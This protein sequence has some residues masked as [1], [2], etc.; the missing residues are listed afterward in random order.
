MLEV[1]SVNVEVT[2]NSP[3][4]FNNTAIKKGCTADVSSSATIQ[5]NKRGV[6]MVS[7]DGTSSAATTLQLIKDGIAHPQA[8]ST[9]TEPSFVTLVQVDHDN[10]NC[11]CSSPV[12]LQVVS[13]TAVTL[14]NINLVVTKIC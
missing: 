10:S 4:P 9:G 11:C 3:I 14:E 7:V 12:N 5:L 13:D 2:A 6:Y 1:Y 8:Q